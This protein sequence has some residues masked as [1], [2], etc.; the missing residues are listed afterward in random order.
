MERQRQPVPVGD[1]VVLDVD[2]QKKGVPE[3]AHPRGD[4]GARPFQ[5]LGRDSG[6][7]AKVVEHAVHAGAPGQLGDRADGG[8]VVGGGEQHS[9][10]ENRKHRRE[11]RDT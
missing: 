1:G 2:G 11:S 4:G 10:E 9:G 8:P 3:G 7:A 5:R 6:A